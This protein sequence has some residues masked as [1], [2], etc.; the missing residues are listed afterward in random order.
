MEKKRAIWLGVMLLVIAGG[1]SWEI[2]RTREP[3][4]EGKPLS[5]WLDCYAP[6]NRTETS[7]QQADHALQA[8]GTNAIPT[9]LRMLQRK[10]SPLKLRIVALL[11]KQYIFKIK[12]PSAFE[13]IV[14]AGSGLQALGANAKPAIPGLIQIF[15][16]QASDESRIAAATTLGTIGRPARDAVPILVSS[17]TNQN[18]TT[19]SSV[20]GALG[21]IHSYPELSVPA[22]TQ[23][24]IVNDPF[25]WNKTWAAESL[26]QFG[27]EARPAISALVDLSKHSDPLVRES[28]LQ[29]LQKI[30]P[31]SA[32]R[33]ETETSAN[34]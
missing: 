9:L 30:D 32:P 2:W 25:Y 24:L 20:I 10:E 34:H 6:L 29:A 23:C 1:L 18:D 26:G 15:Q 12:S 21:R 17:L 4:Y 22:L 7:V 27:A 11:E 19:R 5:Y 3:M 28:F 13:Q 31:K 8:I 16:G 14:E 33:F